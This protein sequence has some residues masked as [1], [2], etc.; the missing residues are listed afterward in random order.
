MI[1]KYILF[2]DMY[3]RFLSTYQALSIGI[4]VAPIL[5][6]I[7]FTFTWKDNEIVGSWFCTTMI[8]LF[9]CVILKLSTMNGGV[10]VILWIVLAIIGILF[11][12]YMGNVGNAVSV[13]STIALVIIFVL[14]AFI[15][16]SILGEGVGSIGEGARWWMVLPVLA[17][18]GVT[19]V[20]TISKLFKK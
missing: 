18:F 2:F 1:F 3:F 14:G 8:L 15:D 12:L 17:D 19:F 4:W 6:F 7:I 11:A 20:L 5:L 10:G 16:L 9:E 13:I